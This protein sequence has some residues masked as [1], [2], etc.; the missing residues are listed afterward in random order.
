MTTLQAVSKKILEVWKVNEPFAYAVLAEYP[1]PHEIRYEVFEPTLTADE[2]RSLK[3]IRDFLFEQIDVTM[4]DLGSEAEAAEY[5]KRLT[6]RIIRQFRIPVKKES[7]EKILYYI[8]R[9]YVGYGKIDVMMKDPLIEDISCNGV[10]L[11]IYVWHRDY[12]S[13]PTNVVFD[14]EESLDSFIVRLAYRAGRMISVANP[15]LDAALPDG[16]RIQLTLGRSVTRHGSTFTIRKFKTD[17]FTIVDLIRLNTLSSHMAAFFWLLIENKFNIFVC[18]PTASGKTTTLNCLSNFIHPDYKIVTIEETP[19]IRLHHKNWVRSVSRP[20]YGG[21]A[22]ITLFDLLKAAM[23][24]R[25]DYIIVGEVRGSE[26]YTLFQAMATG[27]GGLSSLHAESVPA[28]VHRLENEPI[29]IPRTLIAGLNVIT[30]QMRLEVNG[31]PARRTITTTEI[32]GIDP[33]TNEIITNETFR[34]KPEA[35]TYAYSG[36]SYSLERLAKNTGMTMRE[37]EEEITGR[38][39]I[40]DW[41]VR[42]NMRSFSEVAE[43]IRGFYS[44]P[45]ELYRRIKIGA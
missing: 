45:D 26:A 28:A 40:L 12:E 19:E 24:Q 38:M 23:R 33:R 14:S 44:N 7:L 31:K 36:R 35:D 17:P 4:S 29:N 8:V 11:P 27:H 34:Y 39:K 20:G 10:G 37:I 25:P 1:F 30:V 16:S 42:H 22:E 9:D 21:S 43:I 3:R 2:E 41:M 13:I 15:I 5:L 6:M 18:G 32:L